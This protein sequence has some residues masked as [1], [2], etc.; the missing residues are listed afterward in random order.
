MT[1]LAEPLC[2]TE[3]RLTLSGLVSPPAWS[4]VQ[5]LPGM[6]QITELASGWALAAPARQ[7]AATSKTDER[8][9]MCVTPEKAGLIGRSL[10]GTL[11]GRPRSGCP[12]SASA[13][14]E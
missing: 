10:P 12:R 5:A 13:R 2:C 1:P 8:I 3:A 11:C 14:H 4:Q 6:L 7:T 9:I